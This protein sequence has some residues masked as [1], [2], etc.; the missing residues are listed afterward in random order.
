MEHLDGDSNVVSWTYEPF[1]IPY[2]SNKR[3]GK[4]RLYKPDFYV[5]L[6]GGKKL[7]IEVKP[8]RRLSN[9]TV[10]KKARSARAWCV[11]NDIEYVFVTE[12]ELK[13]L[14]VM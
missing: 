4:I 6:K 9:P 13:S 7:L 1:N 14:G 2:V 11:A 8:S 3:T 10:V 12:M 5:L